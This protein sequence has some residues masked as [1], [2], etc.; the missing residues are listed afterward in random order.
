MNFGD[1]EAF[2]AV[3]ETGSVNRAAMRLNLTQPATTRRVQNFEA[4][5]GPMPLFNR[6]VKPAVLTAFGTEILAQC[7]RVLAAVA[8]LEASAATGG[9]PCGTLKLGIAHGLGET[10]LLTPLD[11]VRQAFSRV[12]LQILSD[13]SSQ[14][15]EGVRSGAL[16]AAIGLLTDAHS[17]P[18]TVQGIALGSEQIVIVSAAKPMQ[19]PDGTPWRLRDLASEGWFLNPPGCGCRAALTR[20]C[21]RLQVDMQLAVEVFGEELQ[22]AMLARGGGLGLVPRRQ[23][24]QSPHRA[25]LRVLDVLDFSLAATITLM[26]PAVSGRFDG[27]LDRLVQKLRIDLK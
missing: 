10:V 26:R 9:E 12:R 21:N 25:T 13:W 3:A 8:A 24:E 19:H 1:L 17:L 11:I 23:L 15:I 16:D 27:L 4:S 5:L 18:P 2:V 22:L 6:A 20:A 14:L 7:C